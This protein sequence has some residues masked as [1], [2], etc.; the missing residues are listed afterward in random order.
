[1]RYI[2]TYFDLTMEH[3]WDGVLGQSF[4][5][6]AIFH[7]CNDESYRRA[8]LQSYQAR[9]SAVLKPWKLDNNDYADNFYENEI[10]G[11]EETLIDY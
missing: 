3:V 6:S 4:F 7:M 9:T 11:A 10:R 8:T 5:C 1:M 2:Q